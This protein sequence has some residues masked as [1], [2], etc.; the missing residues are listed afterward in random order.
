MG[1]IEKETDVL[2]IGGGLA[3]C[4]AAIQSRSIGP[5][6][7]MVDKAVISRS[8]ASAWAYYL[9]AP[10]EDIAVWKKELVE[11]GDYLNDQDWVDVLLQEHGQRIAD[12]AEWG[13]PF[14][15][16]EKGNLIKK[17]GR[18]H[19]RTRFVTSDGR[20]RMEALKRK[21]RDAGVEIV[22]RVMCTDLLTSD[23]LHP[24]SGSVI[25]AIGFD[26]RTG[27]TLVFRSKAVVIASGPLHPGSNLSGDGTVMAFR[28]GAEITGMEFC[29]HPTCFM[30]DGKRNL[31]SLNVLFQALGLR[32]VNNRGERFMEKYSP[33]LMERSDW[34]VLAQ[35][36]VKE[37]FDGRGP[38]LLDMSAARDE[39]IAY[40]ARLHPGRMA[41]FRET[42]I[43]LKTGRIM[44]EP[45]V[46]VS[47]SSG[48]GGIRIDTDGR[49]G[50]PGLFGA[51]S[52][53]KNGVHG[54]Y[55]VG[56][57]NLAFCCSSGYR[58]GDSA[59]RY[60]QH[61]RGSRL[62]HRP[63]LRS[64]QQDFFSRLGQRNFSPSTVLA[65]KIERAVSPAPVSIIKREDRIRGALEDLER[66][67]QEV[68]AAGAKDIHELV[69]LREVDNLLLLAN[70]TFLSALERKESRHS[71]YR[72]EY[73]FRDDVDWLKWVVMK[74]TG[75]KGIQIRTEPLAMERY[76]VKPEPRQRIASRIHF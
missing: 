25:G 16:D 29:T 17:A 65:N 51:G 58:A 69:K 28:A 34:A 47:S 73:P 1:E 74:N 37:T 72:Q 49:T 62:V 52:A 26:T 23:G 13:V 55:S 22:E 45:W 39:D 48:D 67:D 44:V 42:G 54:T 68:K 18:G 24:T 27:D 76:S 40:F 35:A 32:L 30:T 63:Q 19:D 15:R 6:V 9:L 20:T 3:G 38:I 36:I 21:A 41:P 66:L 31:G 14:E 71:H 70:L 11:K 50:I 57:I 59:A 75:E 61:Q 33:V 43:D 12:M 7:T 64:L 53:C 2:I 5:R 4:L 60:S 10:P 8:G 56:G 46:S